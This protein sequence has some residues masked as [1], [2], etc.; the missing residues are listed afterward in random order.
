MKKGKMIHSPLFSLY[1]LEGN[2][3]SF[4]AVAS[5]KVSKKAVIRNRNKRRVR[6]IFR[7]KAFS[8]APGGYILIIKKDL[9][10]LKHPVLVEEI[11]HILAK[12]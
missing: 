9:E 10:G 3:I 7:K 12:A 8:L 4:S 1:Y 5:K 11:A 2:T 6:E